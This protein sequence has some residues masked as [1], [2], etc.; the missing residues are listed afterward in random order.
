RN[1]GPGEHAGRAAAEDRQS[2]LESRGTGRHRR[3]R[4][5]GR[6]GSSNRTYARTSQELFRASERFFLGLFACSAG[7]AGKR[8]AGRYVVRLA[9]INPVQLVA[10]KVYGPSQN[11]DFALLVFFRLHG[12][13]PLRRR[14]RPSRRERPPGYPTRSTTR[15]N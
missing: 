6:L 2:R 10:G 7:A 13:T 11:F 14:W 5:T 1:R 8:R 4:L 12:I 3:A 9:V 15:R